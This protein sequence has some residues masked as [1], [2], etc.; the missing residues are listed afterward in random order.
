MDLIGGFKRLLRRVPNMRV[1]V[2]TAQL[3]GAA[4]GVL[5]AQLCLVSMLRNK[6]LAPRLM[7]HASDVGKALQHGSLISV[8]RTAVSRQGFASTALKGAAARAPV[9][10][11]SASAAALYVHC[12]LA[13]LLMRRLEC[14]VRRMLTRSIR[15]HPSLCEATCPRTS[16]SLRTP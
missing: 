6:Y 12:G 9:A 5:C 2:R 14:G 1:P 10:C 3:L 16:S 7:Q 13:A 15:F 8:A 4:T 11:C